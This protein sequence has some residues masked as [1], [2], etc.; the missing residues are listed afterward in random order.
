M[1]GNNSCK[2]MNDE[3]AAAVLGVI[4]GHTGG[5][6]CQFCCLA[7]VLVLLEQHGYLKTVECFR[8]YVSDFTD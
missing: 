7:L 1:E 2:P 5:R 6:D 3:Q 8:K 4:A